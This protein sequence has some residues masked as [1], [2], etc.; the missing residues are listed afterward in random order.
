MLSL[1]A[2][3]RLGWKWMAVTNNLA[4]YDK[5]T[6]TAVKSFIVQAPGWKRLSLANTLVYYNTAIITTVKSVMVQA[7]QCY[8]TLVC[9]KLLGRATTLIITTLSIMA[10]SIIWSNAQHK[11]KRSSLFKSTLFNRKLERLLPPYYNSTFWNKNA[12]LR[13]R[14]LTN[15]L[16]YCSKVYFQTK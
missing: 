11:I 6:I 16:A 13:W 1:P 7:L 2:N 15:T 9:G 10:L 5:A 8:K 12:G 4:Y 14:F 3:I